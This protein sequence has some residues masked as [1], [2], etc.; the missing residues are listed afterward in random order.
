MHDLPPIGIIHA[1]D[2]R[3]RAEAIRQA[4]ARVR[5][6]MARGAAGLPPHCIHRGIFYP[7]QPLRY[8]Y[9]VPV[10]ADDG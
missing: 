4:A 6:A 10:D 8:P 7:K 2:E 9:S 5:A 1:R 3:E